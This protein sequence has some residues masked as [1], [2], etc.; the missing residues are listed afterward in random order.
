MKNRPD[1]KSYLWDNLCA[2]M[3]VDNPSVDAVQRKTKVGRGTIQRIKEG[4]TSVGLDNLDRI[5]SAFQVSV[6]QLLV[7]ELDPNSL[8]AL[9]ESITRWPFAE[10]PLEVISALA[11][12]KAR[13]VEA[14]LKVALAAAGVDLK[15]GRRSGTGG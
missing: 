1:P 2:L 11:G 5:A 3:R 13:S 7:P 4:Q 9:V 6:W 12:E 14:G 15:G 10:V 8:P